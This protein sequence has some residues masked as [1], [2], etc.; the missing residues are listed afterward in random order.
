MSRTIAL[1]L[2]LIQMTLVSLPAR[3]QETG[4]P[5][6]VL[7]IVPQRPLIH[8]E[9]ARHLRVTAV[10]VDIDALDAIATTA[11]SVTVANDGARPAEAEL[12]MP[13]PDG[14]AIRQFGIE[15]LGEGTATLLP[16]DEARRVYDAIV[17]RMVDPGLLEFIGTGA[18]R[19]SVFPVPPGATQT[20]TLTYEQVLPK[21][22]N[23]VDYVLP[24]SDALAS[25]GAEW[26]M[27]AR[28]R[29]SSVLGAVYSP[30]HRVTV[31]PAGRN[32]MRVTA[33][34]ASDPGPFRL[35][36]LTSS[37]DAPQM[38]VIA[39][40]DPRR[41]NA[42]GYFL[43]LAAAPDPGPG[44]EVLEREVTVVIDRS[45]SMKGEK[46]EQAKAAAIDVIDGLRPG[47]SFNIIDYS[48][49]VE[50]FAPEPRA[51]SPAS[52]EAARAYVRA[53]RAR[54][55]TNLNDALVEALGGPVP[56]GAVPMVLFLTDGLPTVGVRDEVQ[57]KANAGK[58]NDAGRRVFTFGVGYD[59]NTPLLTGVAGATRGSATFVLP[60]EDIEVAVG[61]VADKLDG[62]VLTD[63]T[64]RGAPAASTGWDH[65]P[66]LR[67]LQPG[68]IPDM[69][70]GEH[71]VV[72]G[73]Y[74]DA[75]QKLTF[76]LSGLAG[77]DRRTST[78]VFDPSDATL[79]HGYV[80]RIWAQRQIAAL[81]DAI[82]QAGADG[83]T[84]E[85][86]LVDEIVRL[87]LE[88]GVLTEYTAYLAAE[89]TD[90][91]DAFD[92]DIEDGVMFLSLGEGAVGQAGQNLDAMAVQRRAGRGAVAQEIN[93]ARRLG[94]DALSVQT[95]FDADMR[96]VDITNVQQFN[97][98]PMI[99]R[100]NQ[101][102]EPVLLAEQQ[103]EPDRTVAFGTPEYDAL[104][105]DLVAQHRQGLLANRGEVLILNRGQRILVR[106]P[107]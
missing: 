96:R 53:I 36:W 92:R 31:E 54:G 29:T 79:T 35:S 32:A 102:V 17:R 11:I 105:E 60:D 90:L 81:V 66:V 8:P 25:G 52:V 23:R 20:L 101:W 80:P 27:T 75:S 74:T 19:S 45:G 6:R 49:T 61:A 15:G 58:A 55:G 28:V 4:D 1:V 21:S 10:S 3:A 70:K 100:R 76:E 93:R 51:V 68:D 84:P 87:S 88:F 9:G 22:D 72:A 63:V 56:G 26:S 89:E 14:V 85:K 37:G 2:A 107:G 30:S 33:S 73:R 64:L 24:R 46:I 103:Q 47:D 95:Y 69:F 98:L 18:V 13:V 67:D 38:S 91:A 40:P 42:G 57:I 44:T 48:S 39:C 43:L 65:P 77:D 97:G 86:E 41:P 106:N 5:V 71:L 78:L 12:I 62:P 94:A 59:V 50:R 34:N 82:R 16:R 7:P 99:N 83:S 104:L